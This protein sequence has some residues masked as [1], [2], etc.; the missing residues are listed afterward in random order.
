MKRC[1]GKRIKAERVTEMTALRPFRPRSA[2]GARG[3]RF[4][5]SDGPLNAADS[6]RRDELHRFDL[7]A[8]VFG[9]CRIDARHCC[10]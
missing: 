6:S 2:D 8:M 9:V 7:F 5:R 4:D 10:C 3:V 1:V